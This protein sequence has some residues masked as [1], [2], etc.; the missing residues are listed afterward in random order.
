MDRRFFMA[1]VLSAL[2]L[3]TFQMF[4]APKQPTEPVPASPTSRQEPADDTP[5]E[6]RSAE[7]APGEAGGSV[8]QPGPAFS[9]ATTE[10]SVSHRTEDYAV[11]LTNRG[12]RIESWRLL[13]YAGKTGEP[14]ELVGGDPELDLELETDSGRIDLGQA[15]YETREETLPDGG[16]R[17]VF[18]AGLEEGVQITKTYTL[19]AKGY[20]VDL[21]VDISG[22]ADA[23]G[24]RLIW[25]E[26]VP[27]AE[28]SPKLDEQASGTIA[29]LGSQRETVRPGSFKRS[30]EKVIE[31]NVR[32]V[33]VRNKY[34]M[35]VVVPP[36]GSTSRVVA[37]GDAVTRASGAEVVMPLLRGAGSDQF[38]VYLGPIDYDGLKSCGHDLDRAV[39][40]GWNIFRP[41]SKALLWLMVWLH[42]IIP[43]YG[44]VII[45]VSALTKVI[46][47][48]LTRTSMRSMKAM[49]HL[50]PQI[51]AMQEKYKGDP[52]RSQAEMMK[53]YKE[54][55]VNPMGG[56]LPI[57]VQMPVFFALYSVLANSIAMRGAGFMLWMNDLSVP[58]TIA[59]V[60]GFSLHV[61]PFLLFVTT[62]LQQKLTPMSADPRQKMMGY[63][64]PAVMLFIFYSFPAGLNLYWTVNNILT[65]AQQWWIQR[66]GSGAPARA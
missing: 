7:T 35:A 41:I 55:K 22:A 49:Q 51:K 63:M 45:I 57:V 62:I 42:S 9:R 6:V 64:M 28:K 38:K 25:R 37:T 17:V 34:F 8:Q 10:A 21:D 30:T 43:N 52:Q 5:P 18:S 19:P 29:L 2:V 36:D 16:H 4:L 47:Y 3:I 48:P 58:D 33:G 50:Q 54:N 53:L 61:L 40:L 31:G 66:E 32:W 44:V 26:A 59:T 1:I 60:G 13:K 14:V 39:D 11:T 56:C 15:L 24:Y 23:V 65:V 20:L 46:F 12:A 27:P